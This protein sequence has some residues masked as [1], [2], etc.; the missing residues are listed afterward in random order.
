M[1]HERTVASLTAILIVAAASAAWFLPDGL[2]AWRSGWAHPAAAKSPTVGADHDDEETPELVRLASAD[3]AR[4]IGIE[5]AEADLVRHARRLTCNAETAF[6]EQRVA[7]V[8]ARVDGI[9]HDVRVELSQVVSRGDVLAVID[10]A[11]VGSA[12]TQYRTAL[13]N[14]DLAQT[15][16]ERIRKLAEKEILAGKS[17]LE[18]VTALTATKNNLLEAEQRLRNLGFQS[19]DLAK[20]AAAKSADNLWEVVAPIDGH[21]IAWESTI[22]EAVASGTQ[23]FG[24]A[25]TT[26]MWLWIDVYESDIDSIQIGQPATFTISG[27]QEPLFAGK[28]TAIGAEVNRITRTTRVR[29]ELAN[30]EGRLRANQ[31]GQA[32][33]EIVP[34]HEAVVVPAEAVQRDQENR[35]LVFLPEGKSAYRA[36]SIVATPTDDPD[37]LEIVR[38]LEAGRTVVTTGAFLLLSEMLK[39]Q[40]AED[41]D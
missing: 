18:A 8:L 16:Y 3:L 34:E 32:S 13:A 11:T 37:K 24:L 27:T 26:K 30:P 36:R 28:I 33:I 22:G 14:L 38:G 40:I 29:A 4:Q 23:L 21:V 41:V 31:F 5:T 6:A 10:S 15:T 1:K 25:D 35:E 19:D 20:I 12:K 9:V 39:D 2:P 17:E 7:E